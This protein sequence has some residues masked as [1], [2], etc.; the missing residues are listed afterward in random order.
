MDKSVLPKNATVNE[1][2]T[3]TLKL[4]EPIKYGKDTVYEQLI[5]K[6][7][8]AKHIKKM[9]LQNLKMEDVMGLAGKLCGE[10]PSVLD[11]LGMTDLFALGDV[12]NYFLPD[13]DSPGNRG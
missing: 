11:E 1:D 10:A 5:F 13:G 4:S 8:K 2:G 3:V 12:I 9:D 7:P 6:K